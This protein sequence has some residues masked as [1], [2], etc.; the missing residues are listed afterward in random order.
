MF[1]SLREQFDKAGLSI[2]DN[3]WS[4]VYDFTPEAGKANSVNVGL[5]VTHLTLGVKVG[6]QAMALD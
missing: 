6:Q 1:L 4:E 5:E 3:R 2:W